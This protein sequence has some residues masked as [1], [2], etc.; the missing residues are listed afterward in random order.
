MTSQPIQVL[1]VEDDCDDI[2]LVREQLEI[3][4]LAKFKIETVGSISSALERLSEFRPDVVLLDLNLPDSNGIQTITA[5]IDNYPF[6]PVVVYSS[7]Q[8]DFDFSLNILQAGAQD[9]LV[10][11]DTD[12]KLLSRS[13]QYAIHRQFH[14][15]KLAES[16]SQLR[17]LIMNLV[18]RHG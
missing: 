17:E 11:G 16:E 9:Y 5:I 10:K 14:P 4:E 7:Y 6:L 12:L 1:Y 18:V 2:L 3:D 15:K 8:E 13:I